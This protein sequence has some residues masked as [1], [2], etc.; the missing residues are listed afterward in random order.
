MLAA[1]FRGG[2]GAGTVNF[3]FDG[4][5]PILRI[6]VVGTLGYVALVALL[7]VSGKR[8]L[9]Q[10]SSFDFVITVAIGAAFGR[11]LTTRAIPLAEAVTAFTLLICLQFLVSS[12]HVRWRWLSSVLSADPTL[13]YYRGQVRTSALRRKRLTEDELL[14]TVRRH[15]A[16]ALEEVAAIV[17]EP[18]GSLSVIKAADL[19][20]GGALSGID[21]V[22]E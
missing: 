18:D 17:M 8:T 10:M 16:G 1:A 2:K 15:G 14:A 4:W 11:V 22:E 19:G 12:L 5:E 6:L 9:A 7:R 20:G 13:L 21:D 3:F